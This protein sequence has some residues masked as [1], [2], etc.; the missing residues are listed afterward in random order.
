MVQVVKLTDRGVAGGGSG[1]VALRSDPLER[2]VVQRVR[3]RVHLLAPAPE[4][5]VFVARAQRVA[6]SAHRP[7]E[8]VAVGIVHRRHDDRV[9]V[10]DGTTALHLGDPACAHDDAHVAHPFPAQS[11][12]GSAHLA[13]G[14]E[15]A[16]PLATTMRFRA[17]SVASKIVRASSTIRSI[18]ASSWLGS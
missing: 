10:R 7:L 13:V 1:A 16:H 6:V 11:C 17:P 8:R 4:V 5:V 12:P 18:V 14:R 9:G 2:F 3:Q 15:P